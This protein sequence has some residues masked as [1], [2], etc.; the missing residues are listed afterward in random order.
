M[1][2]KSTS[3]NERNEKQTFVPGDRVIV[4]NYKSRSN[5]ACLFAALA[6]GGKERKTRVGDRP[7]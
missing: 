6:A 5:R 1:A 3:R 4:E 7:F 2:R